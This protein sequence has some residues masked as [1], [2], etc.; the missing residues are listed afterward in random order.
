MSEQ[1]DVPPTKSERLISLLLRIDAVLQFVAVAAVFM[2]FAWMGTIHQWLGL[3][4]FPDD[5]IVEYLSRSLSA[6][7]LVHGV[8]TYVIA[9][10]VRR[11]R[12][13]IRIWALSFIAL[14]A[15]TIVIDVVAGL[16]LFWTLSEGPFVIGFGLAILWLL[17]RDD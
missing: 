3:G 5:P 16:P 4:E 13:L 7:Y 2:P 11:Y 8:I 15:I 1:I 12:P 17:A 14:G 6:F 10:D 9:G